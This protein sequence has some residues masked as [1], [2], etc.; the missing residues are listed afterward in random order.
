MVS[1]SFFPPAVEGLLPPVAARDGT[2]AEKFIFLELLSSRNA[3]HYVIA[4]VF[5]FSPKEKT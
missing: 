4:F 3:L 1:V 5:T 2:A